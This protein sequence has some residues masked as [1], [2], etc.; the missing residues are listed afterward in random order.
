MK[1]I[2]GMLKELHLFFRRHVFI[3]CLIAL[4]VFVLIKHSKLPV[5]SFL[6]KWIKTLFLLPSSESGLD[7][8]DVLYN[9]S[10]AVIAAYIF[11]L[12]LQYYNERK[13]AH[14]AFQTLKGNLDSLYESMSYL[15]FM[16]FF[17][18]GVDKSESKVSLSDLIALNEKV[19]DDKTVYCSIRNRVNGNE[20]NVGQ[21]GY[22]IVK[23]TL[24]KVESIKKII[25]TIENHIQ[26]SH[27]D[28]GIV[29]TITEIKSSSFLSLSGAIDKMT[30]CP[31]GFK[32]ITMKYDK[33][34]L[35]FIGLHLQLGK[36]DI[37][38][39]DFLFKKLSEEEIRKRIIE[40]LL[41]TDRGIILHIG[42]SGTSRR[43]KEMIKLNLPGEEW[44]KCNGVLL[45]ILVAYDTKPQE[46]SGILEQAEYLAKQLYNCS[47]G[48]NKLLSYINLLQVCKRRRK[49]FPKEIMRL[50]NMAANTVNIKLQ[51]G[52]AIIESDRGQALRLFDT[53]TPQEKEVF[54]QFPIYRLWNNPPVP[55]NPEPMVFTKC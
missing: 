52:A 49:L 37:E 9:L 51:L 14:K 54:L 55:P 8:L 26:Y 10:L 50:K 31:P 35:A 29:D 36:N 40:D 12:L 22:N 47:E 43:V 17:E 18:L 4:S 34:L 25:S 23:D 11:Y 33:S 24:S 46:L 45:E 30:F 38:K 41:I 28:I 1:T 48:D 6:P 16:F 3:N 5:W 15:I 19:F 39:R 42:V 32:H 7:V 13:A 53:L 2:N 44:E 21:F 20:I 27:L